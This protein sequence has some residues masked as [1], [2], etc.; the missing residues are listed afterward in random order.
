MGPSANLSSP[1]PIQ[2]TPSDSPQFTVTNDGT[3]VLPNGKTYKVTNLTIGGNAQTIPRQFN[4]EQ[5]KA[6][7]RLINEI[8]SKV[9]ES[10][11]KEIDIHTIKISTFDNKQTEFESQKKDNTLLKNHKLTVDTS[12]IIQEIKKT[13]QEV[14]SPSSPSSSSS[15][16]G[17]RVKTVTA[18]KNALN[19]PKEP[20][21]GE[22]IGPGNNVGKNVPDV[23]LVGQQSIPPLSQAPGA[24]P[25][26]IS[27][28][29][30]AAKLGDREIIA[31]LA[32]RKEK[33]GE[34]LQQ[35][36]DINQNLNGIQTIER[37]NTLDEDK[38]YLEKMIGL[39]TA[40]IKQKTEESGK[41]PA[42]Q[43]KEAGSK[44]QSDELEKLKLKLA[45]FESEL[46]KLM[47]SYIPDDGNLDQNLI[48][49]FKEIEVLIKEKEQIKTNQNIS[50]SKRK[51]L[52]KECKR[53]IKV[54]K[55]KIKHTFLN[56]NYFR[57]TLKDSTDFQ[58]G[59]GEYVPAAINL[60]HQSLKVTNKVVGGKEK[61]EKSIKAAGEVEDVGFCR[62]G[63]ISDMR[64]GWFSLSDL[65]KLQQK[66]KEPQ[67]ISDNSPDG[68]IRM[69]RSESGFYV[70]HFIKEMH[71]K[72][73]QLTK[74]S[75]NEADYGKLQ[76]SPE[77]LRKAVDE[78]INKLSPN[79]QQSFKYALDQINPLQGEGL[80]EAQVLAEIDKAIENRQRVLE[81]QMIQLVVTQAKKNPELIRNALKTGH[82]DMI[83]VALLNPRKCELDKTGWLHDECVEMEDMYEIFNAFQ[84]KK[85]VLDG[86]GPFI[87]GDK[88]HLPPIEGIEI[89]QGQEKEVSLNTY[90]VNLSVQGYIDNDPRQLEINKNQLEKL[91][92]NRPDIFP[93]GDKAIRSNEAYT[94]AQAEG[95]V[96]TPKKERGY[97]LAEDLLMILLDKN[98]KLA[99]SLGCLSAKDRT[100]FIGLRLILR[101]LEKH[102]EGA[103]ERFEEGELATTGLASQVVK[104]NTNTVYLKVNPLAANLR[105]AKTANKVAFVANTALG[106]ISGLV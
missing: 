6:I 52:K 78:A 31:A 91:A 75:M 16:N 20:E 68:L 57:Q 23:Q 73:F 77:L 41:I 86:Q 106:G 97:P 15:S 76:S 44:L 69:L 58:T 2:P 56:S 29:E 72:L 37:V 8:L 35:H 88:I 83:H 17:T 45:H 47:N 50:K 64:N 61:D 1:P 96:P 32:A 102:Q 81:R 48:T 82:F 103:M 85:L 80:P 30:I 46:K 74:V 34:L 42:E 99:V 79:Q 4:D 71:L 65:K 94:K 14:I 10:D 19:S 104:D 60:R 93:Q 7:S 38:L 84:G 62:L 9:T 89:A 13:F 24:A 90:F 27:I 26:N 33:T 98:N 25:Q 53:K 28:F 101:H 105:V 55:G 36:Y 54:L 59:I 66:I 100:G 21:A 40:K 70:D 12:N 92:K 49:L 95:S 67:K 18:E 63:I 3:L 39:Y 87:D 5:I 43:N 51:K 11:L 22:D